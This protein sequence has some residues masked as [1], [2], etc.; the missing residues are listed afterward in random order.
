MRADGRRLADK[1]R[2]H[3]QDLASIARE[4]ARA[5]RPELTHGFRRQRAL[6]K[7][8]A[9]RR[10]ALAAARWRPDRRDLRAR[11]RGPAA[12]AGQD[13]DRGARHRHPDHQAWRGDRPDRGAGDAGRGRG[14][15]RRHARADLRGF[16]PRQPSDRPDA[17]RRS[18]LRRRGDLARLHRDRHVA[19]PAASRGD[20]PGLHPGDR[21]EPRTPAGQ[22]AAHPRAAAEPLAD[23]ARP[24]LHR[25][26]GAGS[27]TCVR[28]GR[29]PGR[30]FADPAAVGAGRDPRLGPGTHHAGGG[31]SDPTTCGRR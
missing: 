20:P 24:R 12:A 6:E 2:N 31:A 22:G 19:V 21:R 27:R 4:A 7:A 15:G 16:R 28:R 11:G 25:R 3:L 23:A 5:A 17:G 9:G 10:R 18:G 14:R 13:D 1:S 30:L 29:P 8:P 26:A